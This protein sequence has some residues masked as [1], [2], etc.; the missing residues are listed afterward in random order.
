MLKKLN[1]GLGTLVFIAMFLSSC[2]A[3]RVD[4]DKAAFQ[5][6]KKVAIVLYTVPMTI[7]YYDDPRK[8]EKSMLQQ[9]AAIASAKNGSQ[10]ASKALLGFTNQ[11]NRENLHFR[12]IS[13]DE[14]MDNVDF[15]DVR[16]K[17][18]RM[19]QDRKAMA[20]SKKTGSG[21]SMA[22]KALSFLSKVSKAT[23]DNPDFE[24]AGPEGFPE[25]GL[26]GEWKSTESALMG[27]EGEMDYVKEA[28]ASLDVDAVLVINEN[29]FSFGCEACAGG[30]GSGSTHT[31]FVATMLDRDGEVIMEM[32]QWWTV[33]GGSAVMAAYVINP[34]QHDALFEKHGAKTARVFANYY[35]E[36]GGK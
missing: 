4:F 2:T 7:E 18:A 8:K 29:G 6:V 34:L 13:V 26:A 9:V 19:I 5:E 16:A 24:G 31:T 20:E 33:G 22:S 1:Y 23:D 32:R 36:E 30:T 11:L 35:R 3:S 14:M 21:S 15:E 10:A 17:Y 27:A 28:I 25:F 12:V